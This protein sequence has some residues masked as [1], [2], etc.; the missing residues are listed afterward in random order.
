MP[1]AG[2]SLRGSTPLT[3]RLAVFTHPW[4]ILARRW[5][6]LTHRWLG[7]S[8]CVLFAMW[9][10]SGIVLMYCDYPA[11][12]DRDRLARAAPLEA[13][14]VRLSPAEAYERLNAI[15]K[16]SGCRLLMFDGRPAYRFEFGRDTLLVYADDGELQDDFPPD[17]LLRSAARWTGQ[18]GARA[19]REGPLTAADQWTV[20]GEYRDLRPLMKYIWPDGEQVYVSS[21]NGEVVQYTTR[22]SRLGAWFGAIP[23][24]LYFTPLR[25]QGAIWNRVVVWASGIGTVA[26]LFGLAVGLLLYSPR[27]RRYRF[28]R[29]PSSIPYAG[30][31]RWHTIFGLL[32]GLV[33]C[34]WV[35][36]GMLSMDPFGWQ[37]GPDDSRFA[38][39]LR[40]PL[41]MSAFTAKSPPQALAES[42]PNTRELELAMF[43][44]RPVYLAHYAPEPA[45]PGAGSSIVIPLDG[46]A[47]PY[48]DPARIT[49]VLAQAA[50]PL[51]LAEVRVVDRYEAYYVDRHHRK[52]LP[53]LAVRLNDR[54]RSLFY[55]DLKTARIAESYANLSRWNRWLYHGLHSF[56]LPWLY[57]HRP[58]WDLA[59]LGMMLGGTALSLTSVIIGWR[60]L[61]Y[62]FRSVLGP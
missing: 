58:S 33:T 46:P 37:E 10:V 32:F 14:R 24:W 15:E 6:I 47:R 5:A 35:F 52:P 11:I 53:V 39:A 51:E 20:S 34:T 44:G 60:R 28:P 57:R 23:H 7:V 56:D 26:S 16:P 42:G 21:V 2:V 3:S 29:G 50:R 45:S 38:Q 41:D 18:S 13:A 43:A 49:Q 31:K 36:S 62:K 4:A 30:Q 9:F 27:R 61:R 40:G 59:V 19:H 8:L 48:F 25:R 22:A 54:D 1:S 55:I 17:L 12:S